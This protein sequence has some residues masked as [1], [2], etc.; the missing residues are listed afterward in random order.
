MKKR[1]ESLFPDGKQVYLKASESTY[2][3]LPLRDSSWFQIAKAGLSERE[4]VLLESL[5]PSTV[6][7][8]VSQDPWQNYLFHKGKSPDDR[9]D[10]IQ[11]LHLNRHVIEM[12]LF[13]EQA[14]METLTSSLP[15][16]V[17][18]FM[19]G[20]TIVILLNQSLY[21][22]V[23]EQLADIRHVLEFDFGCQLTFMLG[24]IWTKQDKED[25]GELLEKEEEVFQYY[26]RTSRKHKVL[27]LSDLLYWLASE[28][29]ELFLYFLDYYQGLMA[30]LGMDEIVG[31]LWEEKGVQTKAAKRLF[32]HRN[33][34]Q[35]RLDKFEEMTGLDLK[36]MNDLAL[37]YL[38]IQKN[39][40]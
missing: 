34:L 20:D 24:Q 4:M 30:Q 11:Y 39:R 27:T 33:T 37:T 28:A 5:M 21:F 7:A 15:N 3:Y 23:L 13:D 18:W 14:F 32:L 36:R 26:L 2:Y 12:N 9:V 10:S 25:W 1:L 40:F 31:A 6:G 19:L 17:T 16:C 38:A 8:S 35:H 22:S 29:H